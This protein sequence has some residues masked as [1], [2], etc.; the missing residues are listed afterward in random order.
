MHYF[1]MGLF[2]L[3]YRVF[4]IR[5]NFL[6]FKRSG[7]IMFG[8]ISKYVLRL[9]STESMKRQDQDLEMSNKICA[10]RAKK[11]RGIIIYWLKILKS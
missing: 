8:G 4:K 3:Y 5:D 11:L 10:C 2:H 9:F 7:R 1:L 6:M